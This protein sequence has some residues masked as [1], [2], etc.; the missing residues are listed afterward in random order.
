M[1]SEPEE[2]LRHWQDYRTRL[3]RF[4]RSR[5]Q[6]DLLA[7]D[8]VHDALVKAWQNR[9][10][11]EDQDAVIPWLFQI[12]MNTI[13]DA[14]RRAKLLTVEADEETLADLDTE[15]AASDLA[16]RAD[17]TTCLV[18]MIDDLDPEYRSTLVRSEIDGVPMRV[19]ADETGLSISGVKSRVQRARAQ[20]RDA[21]LSCCRIELNSRGQITNADDHDCAC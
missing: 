14:Q 11:L 8:I 21:M 19:I 1:T 18:S 15:H 3:L 16:D 2:S 5:V 17:F 4:A 10:T 7:E 9:D 6:D 12:T 20:L 13:R